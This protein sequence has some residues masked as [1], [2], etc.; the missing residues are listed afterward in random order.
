M[1]QLKAYIQ[2]AHQ[3]GQADDQIRQSLIRA[4]WNLEQ[5]NVALSVTV[6]PPSISQPAI[7]QSQDIAT[8]TVNTEQAPATISPIRLPKHKSKLSLLLVGV[9]ALLLIIGGSVF[10][11]LGQTKSYQGVIQK[12]ITDMQHDNGKAADKL[13][14]PAAKTH[15]QKVAGTS[16][17]Y[18]AC[19]QSEQLCQPLFSAAFLSKATKKYTSYTADNH[20]KGEEAV[21]TEIQSLQGNQAGGPGCTSK[22]TTTLTIAVVPS[23]N[24]WLV[25]Y[26]NEDVSASA[27][28]CPAAT[29][30]TSVPAS[31][32]ATKPTPV[33]PT[34]IPTA[35]P[36]TTCTPTQSNIDQA[37][38]D[39]QAIQSQLE[40]YFTDKTYYPSDIAY[41]N[42]SSYGADQ[43]AFNP[44]ACIHFVF[45]PTPNGCS[46]ASQ[47]CQHY[48]LYG[49]DT[50]GK[51]VTPQLQSLN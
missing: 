41:S 38:S 25:D 12:F 36:P 17:F 50:N 1:E 10:A 32:T 47:N 19:R 35:T 49:A 30:T 2:Q 20:V 26:I 8:P 6:T 16:S 28:L 39:T 14:S 45:T 44:P 34:K 9:T 11:L 48:V 37:K 21:Y 4:G 22:S 18:T 23:G 15:F 46:T 27:Q 33:N 5:I 13:L 40:A 7:Y 3:Q 24:S 43:N 51:A 31:S 42:F 29:G